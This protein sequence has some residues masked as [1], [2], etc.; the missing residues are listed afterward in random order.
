MGREEV[1]EILDGIVIVFSSVPD[2]SLENLKG[3]FEVVPEI[4]DIVSQVLRS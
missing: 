4:S 3:F 2:S 1:S